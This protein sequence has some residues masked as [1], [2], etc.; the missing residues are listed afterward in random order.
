MLILLGITLF[1]FFLRLDLYVDGNSYHYNTD[2]N[3]DF[4]M[5][6]LIAEYG[7]MPLAGPPG[8]FGSNLNGPLYYYFIAG[9]I[10]LIG[11]SVL[12]LGFINVL[13]QSISIVLVFFLGKLLFDD[14]F[15]LIVATFFAGM[16]VFISQSAHIWQPYI[17]QFFL[18]SCFV[19][20]ALFYR[21]QNMLYLY[22]SIALFCISMVMHNAAFA[23]FPTYLLAVGLLLYIQKAKLMTYVSVASFTTVLVALLLA[24]VL[25][26]HSINTAI[27]GDIEAVT[28]A[29][30]FDVTTIGS[31]LINFFAFLQTYFSF[32]PHMVTLILL[33]PVIC[34][35][36]FY[37]FRSENREQQLI[38]SLLSVSVINIFLAFGVI[39]SFSNIDTFQVR[40][41]IPILV[42]FTFIMCL[43]ILNAFPAKYKYSTF[44]IYCVLGVV[45]LACSDLPQRVPHV[46][47]ALRYE[48]HDHFL[49]K[50]YTYAPTK[51]ATL[52][53]SIIKEKSLKGNF[54]F[55]T[56]SDDS[57]IYRRLLNAE[58]WTPI[59]LATKEQHLVIDE[60]TIR[61]Y[62]PKYP[63]EFLF[64]TCWQTNLCKEHLAY[65]LP[66]YEPLESF[67]ISDDKTIIFL[68]KKD[69]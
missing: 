27:P 41:T 32:L 48:I 1:G 42:P 40:Y 6:Y 43:L 65:V 69:L 55:K 20:L 61:G 33:L 60:D 8:Y 52:M 5:G 57:F 12:G 39:D 19:A 37:T 62:R 16:H 54:D 66:D 15:G 56:Y 31:A 35:G 44:L 22:I 46:W 45:L 51:D 59:M 3:R 14:K 64:V 58:L 4:L 11:P 67:Q 53:L 9:I 18:L 63:V 38:V 26:A 10:T 13:I 49:Y 68:E 30:A 21:K 50:L 2:S 24:P 23:I 29:L 7:E 36:I 28:D 17:M 47:E 34:V 25:Y